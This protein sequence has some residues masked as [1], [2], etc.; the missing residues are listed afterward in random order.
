[1]TVDPSR[2]SGGDAD[3]SRPSAVP[4]SRALEYVPGMRSRTWKRNVVVLVLYV[5]VCLV[6]VALVLGLL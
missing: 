1:M 4:S 3:P 2:P 5:E 6:V